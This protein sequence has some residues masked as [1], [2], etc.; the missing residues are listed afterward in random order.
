MILGSQG[1][2][3]RPA[4]AQ[5]RGMCWTHRSSQWD[6]ILTQLDCQVLFTWH[7]VAFLVRPRIY[8]LDKFC[9]HQGDDDLK[10]LGGDE[11]G[12]ICKFHVQL[13]S[14]LTTLDVGARTVP[15]SNKTCLFYVKSRLWFRFWPIPFVFHVP[16]EIHLFLAVVFYLCHAGRCPIVCWLRRVLQSHA[17]V[18][19]DPILYP[20]MVHFGPLV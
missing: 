18:M 12:V 11:T 9:V 6:V 13:K 2:L 14:T 1:L 7:H 15:S 19:D 16:L 8:F 3:G 20:L 5:G 17:L 10:R 4:I